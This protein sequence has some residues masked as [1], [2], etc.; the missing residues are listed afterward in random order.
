MGESALKS[1]G[2]AL[3]G[4]VYPEAC[5]ICHAQRAT[6]AEG[7]VCAACWQDVRFIKPPFCE[8]C[9]LPY[10]G[11]ITTA[12]ECGNCRD[13]KLYFRGA[14]SAVAA[15]GVVLEAI[16]HYKYQR[17]LWFE[18]FLAD[19]LLRAALPEL[20]A[21]SWDIVVPIPLH[22]LKERD[23]EF[24]QAERLGRHLAAALG[25]RQRTDLV[26]RVLPTVTQ[27][28]L[29]RAERA[30]NVHRAFA[31]RRGARLQGEKV[32]LLDDVFTTGAT[33]NA[34]ARVLRSLGAGEVFVWTLARG[35]AGPKLSF[36][37]PAG[38]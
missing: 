2:N 36:E 15:Q 35:V 23:R 20:R 1:W 14:R 5:Q 8:R 29:D 37:L 16:H 21:E 7:Y 32:I 11:E 19:L 12:F 13:V 17:A 6:P 18:P 38:S 28:R 3:L 25:I 10:A 4:F 33:T 26:E 27:T 30:G 34:C 31:A 9:G 24:N 22:R